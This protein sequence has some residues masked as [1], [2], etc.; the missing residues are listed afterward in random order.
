M[1]VCLYKI[2]GCEL[3]LSRSAGLLEVIWINTNSVFNDSQ[4]SKVPEITRKEQENGKQR[5]QL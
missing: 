2:I 1:Y 3:K 4:H 5:T